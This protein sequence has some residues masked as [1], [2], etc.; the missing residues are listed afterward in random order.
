MNDS[1]VRVQNAGLL[2]RPL[3]ALWAKAAECWAFGLRAWAPHSRRGNAGLKLKALNSSSH[4][5]PPGVSCASQEIVSVLVGYGVVP[6]SCGAAAGAPAT[7]T[8]ADVPKGTTYIVSIVVP[9]LANHAQ[10][11]L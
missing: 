7:A 1:C 2:I 8:P 4:P 3:E 9:F 10:S 6:T 11:I 5:P